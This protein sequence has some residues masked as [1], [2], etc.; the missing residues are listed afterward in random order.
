MADLIRLKFQP[1]DVVT[2]IWWPPFPQLSKPG[3][4]AQVPANHLSAMAI[5]R[6]L[7]S[8]AQANPQRVHMVIE[9]MDAH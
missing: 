7:G 3:D 6:Q 2:P 4:C 9:A 5:F 8:H 1:S